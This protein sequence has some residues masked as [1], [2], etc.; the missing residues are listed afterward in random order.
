M[1]RGGNAMGTASPELESAYAD[2][3]RAGHL[4]PLQ[5]KMRIYHELEED[6]A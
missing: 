2:A 3:L 5:R 6:E 4:A 1:T